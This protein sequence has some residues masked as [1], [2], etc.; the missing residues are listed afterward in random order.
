MCWN[1][2]D[3]KPEPETTLRDSAS[4]VSVS[5]SKTTSAF[6][7]L[8][9]K[10]HAAQTSLMLTKDSSPETDFHDESQLMFPLALVISL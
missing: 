3:C 6:R 1:S 8:A 10:K 7:E 2:D 9:A 5:E 4:V